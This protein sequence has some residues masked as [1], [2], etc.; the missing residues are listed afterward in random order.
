VCIMEHY[1][2]RNIKIIYN[3]NDLEYI[4]EITI[5]LKENCFNVMSFF[6]IDKLDKP[7]TIQLWCDWPQFKNKLKEITGVEVPF[8]VVGSSKNDKSDSCS[9]ID[10]LSF[11]Q[12]KKIDYHK[13]ET[14][15]DLKRGILHEFVHICHSQA[16]EYNYPKEIFLIEGVATYLSNEYQNSTLNEP[17][18][19]VLDND[20]YV[21]YENYRY[22]FNALVKIYDDNELLDILTN[23]KK[24]DFDKIINY[25]N[26]KSDRVI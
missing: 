22:L 11:N 5:F 17:I 21:E 13:D 7:V 25:V 18:E 20:S 9:R 3:D 4:N 16:C 23:N 14:I 8:W 12:I 6:K 15:D 26:I 10:Y 24:I 2:S 1:I 19:K